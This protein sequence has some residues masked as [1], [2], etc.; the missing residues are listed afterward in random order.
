MEHSL[1]DIDKMYW[2]YMRQGVCLCAAV[3]FVVLLAGT[4]YESVL[5]PLIVSTIYALTVE[6]TEVNVWRKVAKKSPDSLPTFFMGVSG[7]R[8]MLALIVMFAYFLALGKAAKADMTVFMIIFAVFYV[9]IL[10]HHTLF[11]SKKK[12][13][14]MKE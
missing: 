6:L 11:F 8:F 5:L 12:K 7:L 9:A 1:G 10:I 2:K 3:F 13:G 4:A 14:V